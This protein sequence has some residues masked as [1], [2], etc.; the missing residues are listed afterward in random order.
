MNFDLISA[1]VFYSIIFLLFVI[2]RKRV[3]VIGKV[4]FGF[5]TKR[6][7]SFLKKVGEHRKLWKVVG[8]IAI[9][10]DLFFMGFLIYNL[11]LIAYLNLK[12]I[13]V[14]GVGVVIPG[15]KIPGSP[16]YIPFWYG[17]ISIFILVVVHEF[18][19]GIMAFAEKI[20]VKDVGFGFFLIFPIAFVEPVKKIFERA[21]PISRIRVASMGPFANILLAFSV[22]GLL[23]LT[24]PM[25]T[26]YSYIMITD[27]EK[28]SPAFKA[29]V[30]G[31]EIIKS[32]NGFKIEKVSDIVSVMK[33]VKPGEEI[34]LITNKGEY[35]FN[36]TNLNGEP[37][38]G[39]YLKVGY[40]N[41]LVDVYQNFMSWLGNLNFAIGIIN[42]LPVIGLDGGIMIR[43]LLNM[44]FRKNGDKIF[45]FVSATFLTLLIFDLIV[46]YVHL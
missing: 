30:K 34:D 7:N 18:S 27:V 10:V 12:G 14:P 39:V 16:I 42:L 38:M 22:I 8:T 33:N 45:T 11:S 31:N 43:D 2:F 29:G 9:F 20:K 6:A 24:S 35:K 3:R 21:K 5:T 17:I 1:I 23:I 44:F 46:T 26:K 28:G 32:I 15:V 36:T 41:R 13:S 19:H 37:H 40:S 25:T 4:V